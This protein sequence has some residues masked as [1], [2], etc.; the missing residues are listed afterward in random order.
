VAPDLLERFAVKGQL[1]RSVIVIRIEEIYFQCSRAVMR[2][3]LWDVENWPDII[4]LPSMGQILQAQKAG[5]FD[6][7]AYDKEWPERAKKSLW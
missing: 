5:D 3:G 2:A 7:E 1:P 4:A 6:G